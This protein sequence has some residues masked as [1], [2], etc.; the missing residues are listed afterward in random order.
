MSG[1]F[2]GPSSAPPT[3][4]VISVTHPSPFIHTHHPRRGSLTPL[5]L[6]VISPVPP[7]QVQS[8]EG[9]PGFPIRSFGF[10]AAGGSDGQSDPSRRDSVASVASNLTATR[11]STY[12]MN[13]VA[14]SSSSALFNASRRRPSLTP[15]LPNLAPPSNFNGSKRRSSLTPSLPTLAAPSPTRALVAGRLSARPPSSEGHYQPVHSRTMDSITGT[16]HHRRASAAAIISG[17]DTRRG[18]LPHL[19][20][21]AWTGPGTPTAPREPWNPALASLRGSVDD[22]IIDQSFKFG[23]PPA[24]TT[25]SLAS[26]STGSRTAESGDDP[27]SGSAQRP[28]TTSSSSKRKEL[29]AFELAEQ[30]EADR[31]RRAFLA[32]TYGEDS[33]RARA[34]LSLGGPL[35]ASP[36][37][38]ASTRRQSLLLWERIHKPPEAG[39]INQS[40]AAAFA[41]AAAA[42]AVP[43]PMLHQTLEKEL[44][45]RPS[46][47]INIP[48]RTPPAQ[49]AESFDDQSIWD[50]PDGI[51]PN[52]VSAPPTRTQHLV[53]VPSH[54]ST[55]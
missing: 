53:V 47:P 49:T 30:Q 40:S 31:Q 46:L 42:T 8:L 10:N 12:A 26:S 34:R 23:C 25:A 35:G 44:G 45:R 52:A 16:T 54:V 7:P 15:S 2:E 51:D 39:G 27:A 19:Y 4:S 50:N 29:S 33:R 38:P 36:G 11:P 32:A 14:G 21:G 18:S 55:H 43:A 22:P 9:S 5:G 37:S 24:A 48:M 28:A 13:A 41:A 20:Y 17:S 3:P 1:H 6:N